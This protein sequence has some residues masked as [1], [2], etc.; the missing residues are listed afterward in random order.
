M[1]RIG[2]LGAVVALQPNVAVRHDH[3]A[4]PIHRH[5]VAGHGAD[6]FENGHVRVGRLGG[7]NDVTLAQT[8]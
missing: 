1:A 3:A 6:A 8:A 2:G 4:Q 7:H 5:A